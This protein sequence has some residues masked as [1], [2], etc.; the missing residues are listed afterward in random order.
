MI[1]FFQGTIKHTFELKPRADAAPRLNFKPSF[2]N[3]A[4]YL[5]GLALSIGVVGS[6]MYMRNKK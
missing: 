3:S 4:L 1:G 2:Q 5:A 6:L